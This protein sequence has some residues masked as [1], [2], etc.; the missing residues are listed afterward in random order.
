[1]STRVLVVDDDDRIRHALAILLKR[2]GFEVTTASDPASALAM[3][4]L[5]VVIVDY[6]LSSEVTGADVVRHFKQRLGSA[7][8]CFV[9][10]GQDDPATRDACLAAGATKV[11][12]KPVSP[13]ELR[14]LLSKRT[15]AA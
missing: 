5:D 4:E 2:A 6:H 10:S 3:T 14:R 7:V 11:L 1:M 12:V 15:D 13:V 9:L 8:T